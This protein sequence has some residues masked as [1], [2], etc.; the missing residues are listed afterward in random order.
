MA[1]QSLYQQARE[2]ETQVGSILATFDPD[3]LPVRDR[4][5]TGALKHQLI[6][7]RL[8]VRDYEYAETRADQLRHAKDGRERLKAIQQNIVKASEYHLFSA[9]DVAHLSARIEQL[10]AH[11]A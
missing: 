3:E 2:L 1:E 9:I 11:L 7:A 4:E 10:I 6:D 5:L 8:D